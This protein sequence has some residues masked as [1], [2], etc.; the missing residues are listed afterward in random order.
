MKLDIW[1]NVYAGIFVF[2]FS[3]ITWGLLNW[4]GN[5]PGSKQVLGYVGGFLLFGLIMYLLGLLVRFAFKN[6]VI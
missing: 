3:T 2:A 1:K 4:I 5:I 6:E